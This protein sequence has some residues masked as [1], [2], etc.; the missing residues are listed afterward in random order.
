MGIGLLILR[1]VVGLTMA[2][3][4][5]QKLFGWWRGGG[6]EGTAGFMEKLG[7]RP[8]RQ[9]AV[10]AGACELGGGLLM[11]WG[12]FT[13][14]AAALL[15]AVM[16]VA[17]GTVHGRNGFFSQEGGFEYNLVLAAAALSLA[18][19]GPGTLAL[20][21][22]FFWYRNSVGW[23][24]AALALGLIGGGIPLAVRS[25]KSPRRFELGA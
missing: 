8:G 11:A 21:N 23:G 7:M 10:I 9:F 24:F 2:A 20:D 5:C 15:I 1:L 3:H 4:G 19:T 16:V 14:F 22:I 13:P 6:I 17:V 12:L 25:L 18:F